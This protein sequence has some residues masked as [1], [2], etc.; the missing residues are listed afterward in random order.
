MSQG[1][2]ADIQPSMSSASVPGDWWNWTTCGPAVGYCGDQDVLYLLSAG[3]LLMSMPGLMVQGSWEPSS[4]LA[5]LCHS[6]FSD[7]VHHRIPLT[8]THNHLQSHPFPSISLPLILEED[9]PVSEGSPTPLKHLIWLSL[10]ML[11]SNIQSLLRGLSIL[12][13]TRFLEC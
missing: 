4:P 9:S 6:L 12:V 11:P 1:K 8:R 10:M 7:P 13:K 5:H 2:C 3:F